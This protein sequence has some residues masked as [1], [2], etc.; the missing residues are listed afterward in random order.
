MQSTTPSNS[1]ISGSDV[2]FIN[3]Q[4][5]ETLQQHI[6]RTNTLSSPLPEHPHHLVSVAEKSL[7]SKKAIFSWYIF[8]TFVLQNILI[9]Y[10]WYYMDSQSTDKRLYY[11]VFLLIAIQCI[12]F[13]YYPLYAD[14]ILNIDIPLCNHHRTSICLWKICICIECLHIIYLLIVNGVVPCLC[15]FDI[16][17]ASVASWCPIDDSLLLLQPEK[18]WISLLAIIGVSFGWISVL[19]L[20]YLLYLDTK[21]YAIWH[22]QERNVQYVTSSGKMRKSV[23]SRQHVGIPMSDPYNLEIQESST[24]FQESD[25]LRQL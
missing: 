1:I 8:I 25:S 20:L 23:S 15:I 7:I 2:L 9:G 13:I 6:H 14:I 5:T 11:F 22:I 18:L 10:A 17:F 21:L 24:T 12:V 16:Y 4:E 3:N 19:V